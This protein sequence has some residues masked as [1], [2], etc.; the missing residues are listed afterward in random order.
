MSEIAL[1]T[2][3]ENLMASDSMFTEL[4]VR[5]FL[6][7]NNV[8]QPTST[9]API[10]WED[11]N[12]HKSAVPDIIDKGDRVVNDIVAEKIMAFDP[13]GVEIYPAKLLLNNDQA[14][15][16]Y[17]ISVKNII[18]VM[19]DEKSVVEISPVD[20]SLR[21]RRLYISKKKLLE[22]PKQKR[23]V[24]RVKGTDDTIFFD[25]DIINSVTDFFAI[26]GASGVQI[27]P[28][29]TADRAPIF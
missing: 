25:G 7:G 4:D 13:Y 21:V 15:G 11:E 14:D 3:S 26:H 10:V 22:I 28:F 12:C 17:L 24:F 2:F 8:Y 6:Y 18:D 23:L 19:D 27:T 9:L 16:R 29:N 5:E 20:G 1:G